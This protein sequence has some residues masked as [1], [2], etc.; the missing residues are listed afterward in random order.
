MQGINWKLVARSPWPKISTAFLFFFTFYLLARDI[1][2]HSVSKYHDLK[3]ANS[4]A[5]MNYRGTSRLVRTLEGN[6][7]RYQF[8]IVEREK[9]IEK[10]GGR[11]IPAFPPPHSLFYVLWDFFIPSFTC[12]FPMYRVGLLADGG[13]WV[14]GLDRVL[15]NRPNCIV[16]SLNYQTSAYSTF[17]QDMLKRSPGCRVYE[18]DVVID[19]KLKSRVHFNHFSVADLTVVRYRSLQSVMKKFGHN[20]V[21][22]LKIDLEGSEFATLVSII[23]DSQEKP[24]PFGQLLLEVHIGWSEDMTTVDHFSRWFTRLERAGLRPYY[25]E[26]STMDI[27]TLRVEPAVA[28]WSF[29]NIRGRHALVDDGLP[30]Y[31]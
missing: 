31:P 13:K 16:Y 2:S 29:M 5:L 4:S 28:Y 30:E 26:V 20:W 9:L 21:D 14:C 1:H 18:T 19:S 10:W 7:K 12:P 24:L 23:A 8:T 11:H 25:F 22:I 3:T 6:E 15:Q 27:N 17:E